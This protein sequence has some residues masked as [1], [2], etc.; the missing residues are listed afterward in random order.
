MRNLFLAAMAV[1][2]SVPSFAQTSIESGDELPTLKNAL[3]LS[4][5][6]WAPA[7]KGGLYFQRITAN[8]AS[9]IQG[10]APLSTEIIRNQ[11]DGKLYKDLY[12]TSNGYTAYGGVVFDANLDGYATDFVAAD[13]GTVYLKNPLG[14]LVT[15]TW[16]KGKK[17]E[18]DTVEFNLPQPIFGSASNANYVY[19]MILVKK[20]DEATGD[21]VFTYIPDTLSQTVKFV[22]RNDSLVK[23]GEELLGYANK[24]GGWLGHG[25]ITST[26]NVVD[27]EPTAPANPDAA[28]DYTIAFDSGDERDFKFIKALV[29]GDSFYATG[30]EPFAPNTWVKG[31][32]KDGKV[33]FPKQYVG[34]SQKGGI[35]YHSFFYPAQT[36]SI[37]HEEFGM[38]TTELTLLEEPVVF[39]YDAVKKSLKTDSSFIF[40]V[41]H[42][43]E[44]AVAEYNRS[45][46]VP[47]TPMADTPANP[48]FIDYYPY[49]DLE[50]FC[51]IKFSLP[52]TG[53][54]GEYLAATDMYYNLYLDDE[55]FVFYPD[56]YFNLAEELEDV[57][58]L[59][60]DDWHFIVQGTKHQ[61]YFFQTGFD[62]IGVQ[63]FY[64]F[65]GKTYSSDLV[66]Y[67]VTGAGVSHHSLGVNS[68]SAVTDVTYRD[69]SGRK[70]AH[71]V[72]GVYVKTVTFADGTV[73]TVKEVKR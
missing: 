28:E 62:R 14:T 66:Y 30:L 55:K 43:S 51:W 24:D 60:T 6:K 20:R 47:Y 1:L 63:Q 3:P 5:M 68:E 44:Y 29:D 54:N 34:L 36:D 41:G 2:L 16:L 9:R 40:N 39:D 32:I 46:F 61:I 27:S 4:G 50:G 15:N 73:K 49:N 37:Y 65:G 10:K 72:R 33:S 31:D 22:W 64:T 45:A 35:R 71:P 8:A 25:D 18:G 59:F 19:K 38:W 53:V 23:V 67:D 13:D 56:E 17:A 48:V 7:K 11:P 21:T 70:V 42:N 12:R 57:P 58:Y 69:L 26:L 52:K